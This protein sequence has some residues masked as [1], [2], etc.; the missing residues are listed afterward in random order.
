MGGVRVSVF[1]AYFNNISAISWLS[2]LLV[3][4][5]GVVGENHRTAA[6]H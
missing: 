2:D 6:S 4:E 3:G 1:D 5:T